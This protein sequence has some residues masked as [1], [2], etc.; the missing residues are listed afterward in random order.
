MNDDVKRLLRMMGCPVV[1]APSEAEAT[2]ARL[3]QSGRVDYA[4]T[5]GLDRIVALCHR[6]STLYQIRL[7]I[8]CLFF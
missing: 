6:S 7:Y 5:V 2:C 1:D 3:A 8:R 4:V